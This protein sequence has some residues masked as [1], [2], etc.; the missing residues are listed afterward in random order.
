MR[1]E[2]KKGQEEKKEGVL[3][4]YPVHREMDRRVSSVSP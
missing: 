4:D 2:E 3:I 1:G